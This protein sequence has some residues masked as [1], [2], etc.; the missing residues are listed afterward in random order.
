MAHP[1][2]LNNLFKYAVPKY[3]SILMGSVSEQTAYEMLF[4]KWLQLGHDALA[5]F[6][7]LKEVSK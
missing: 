4:Y 1:I 7:A 6:W 3:I 2:D 5:L